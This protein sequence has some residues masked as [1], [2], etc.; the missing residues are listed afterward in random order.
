MVSQ[1]TDKREWASTV[2]EVH[3]QKPEGTPGIKKFGTLY[4]LGEW[5]QNLH[6]WGVKAET[7]NIRWVDV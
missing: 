5:L 7:I 1:P 6:Y 2:Y 4:H 3:W